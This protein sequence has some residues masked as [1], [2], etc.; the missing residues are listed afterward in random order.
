MAQ[1]V[2]QLTESG[3]KI[4]GILDQKEV[5]YTPVSITPGQAC[6]SCLWYRNHYCHI[7]SNY[8]ETIEPNGWC[9]RHEVFTPT[10]PD[11]TIAP[12]PVMIVEPPMMEMDSGEMEMALPTNRKGLKE[13][14]LGWLK[15]N[16]PSAPVETQERAFT[17]FKG[18]DDQWFW[19]ARHTG[20]YVDREDEIIADHA[21]E[22]YVTRVQ[23]GLAPMPELWTWHT[24]G[25]SHG[26]A[27]YV[28]KSGGFVRAIG[29][30]TGTK[31]QIERAVAYYQKMGD[32]IKLSHMFKYPKQGKRGKVYHAYNTVEITTL[33]DGAEAFPYTTFEGLGT[34]PFTKAQEE[35]FRGIGGEEMWQRVQAADTKDLADT[36]QMDAAG[37]ASKNMPDI[38]NFEGSV[39]PNDDEIKAL[40][41]ANKDLNDRLKSVEG[42]PTLLTTLDSTLKA[43][44]GQISTLQTSTSD[45]LAKANANEKKLLE[46]QAVAPPASKSD[47][48][49]LNERE[50]SLLQKAMATAKQSDQKSL[51]EQMFGSEPIVSGG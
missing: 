25:S 46:Y 34:M 35:M 13:L 23:K 42:L 6:S 36:K 20:K 18:K 51:I 8:P 30:F 39:I 16:P 9:N 43:L 24:K 26:V 27:D 5:Q 44:Q 29:H 45:A 14:V 19:M 2:K 28:W 32:K 33:P 50:T 3:T 10:P 37:V 7:V 1:D 49:L 40:Q 48:T 21:H 47:D 15:P 31:E 12:I 11:I 41:I 4:Q 22:E 38:E 17:A